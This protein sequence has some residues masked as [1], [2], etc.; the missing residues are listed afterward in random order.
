MSIQRLVSTWYLLS[1]QNLEQE[2]TANKRAMQHRTFIILPGI[3]RTYYHAVRAFGLRTPIHGA[4][5]SLAR[6]E[7]SFRPIAVPSAVLRGQGSPTAHGRLLQCHRMTYSPVPLCSSSTQPVSCGA[8]TKSLLGRVII[9][10]SGF[11]ISLLHFH[12][13]GG[14]PYLHSVHYHHQPGNHNK[15]TSFDPTKTA[16]M[17]PFL[18]NSRARIFPF[19]SRAPKNSNSSVKDLTTSGNISKDTAGEPR[20]AEAQKE[21]TSAEGGNEPSIPHFSAAGFKMGNSRK[22]IHNSTAVSLTFQ[23]LN[24]LDIEIGRSKNLKNFGAITLI[25]VGGFVA[26]T[27]LGN[28]DSSPDLN[29]FLDPTLPN[30][31]KLQAKLRG[32]INTVADAAHLSTNWANDNVSVFA[33][34][35]RRIRLFKDSVRQNVLLYKGKYLVVYSVQWEWALEAKLRRIARDAR[36]VDINDAAFILKQLTN[37][38]GGPLL[39]DRVK[40]WN[41]NI[42]DPITDEALRRVGERFIYLFGFEGFA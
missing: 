8:P 18:K 15:P 37:K 34:G 36:F 40:R 42:Y 35:D 30:F 16:T 23:A 19:N 4:K 22:I 10:E 27:Y 17:I 21:T 14:C 20:T 33:A 26:V 2:R 25:A 29:Y 7:R 3:L 28:R 12:S 32:A 6:V 24:Q 41:A 9:S 31:P 13:K 5:R 11:R 39:T 38:A 1:L